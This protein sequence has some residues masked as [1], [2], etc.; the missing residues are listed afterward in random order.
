MH[1]A[2]TLDAWVA[3]AERLTGAAPA[4]PGFALRLRLGPTAR[5]P[6]ICGRPSPCPSVCTAAR[7]HATCA[8]CACTSPPKGPALQAGS[9]Q[10]R[11]APCKHAPW[12]RVLMHAGLVLRQGDLTK[13]HG[14]AIVTTTNEHMR[15]GG[16][17]VRRRPAGRAAAGAAPGPSAAACSPCPAC[18]AGCSMNKNTCLSPQDRAIHRAA[19]PALKE[20]CHQVRC[21]AGS[22]SPPA[23]LALHIV[24]HTRPPA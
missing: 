19:G 11:R 14:C 6:V 1:E 13:F 22:A 12:R 24:H 18:A 20:A 23:P 2:G 3:A 4:E 17:V 21:A 8:A 10:P 9:P 5:E 16:G 7:A 15:P